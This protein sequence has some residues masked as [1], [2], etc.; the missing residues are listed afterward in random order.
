MMLFQKPINLL[1][2]NNV[3]DKKIKIR[4]TLYIKIHGYAE[5]IKSAEEGLEAV[6]IS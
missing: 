5:Q 2:E 4:S 3:Y 6:V 1:D